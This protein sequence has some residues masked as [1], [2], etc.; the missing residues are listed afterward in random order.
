M[1]RIDRIG[2]YDVQLTITSKDGC[3]NT[4][5]KPFTVNGA[6]PKAQ[7]TVNTSIGLCSN[8][9]VSI[10]NNSTV[11]FGNITKIEV[12]WDYQNNPLQKTTDDNPVSGS[13]Y[14]F[15]YPV[16]GS[17]LTKTFEI[18]YVA[19]SGI[20]CVNES[21]QNIILSAS[22][23]VALNTLN[24]VCEEIPSFLIKQGTEFT[25]ISGSAAYSGNGISADG[26]FNPRAAT[27]GT[28]TIRYTYTATNGCAAFA[29]QPIV[30]YE[31]PAVSAGPD[32]TV[33]EGGFIIL[34]GSGSGNNINYLW[35]PNTSINNNQIPAPQVSP[36]DDITY[37]LTV[38]SGDQCVN[39][40]MVFVKVLKTPLI[41][42]AFSP[43]GDGINETWII[44]YLD[45]YPNV[46]VSV[47]NRYGQPVFHSTGYSKYWDGMYNGKPLPAGTYYYIID[48]RIAGTKKLSGWVMILR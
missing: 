35:T 21:S 41:P 27:P 46:D 17:P 8:Q 48:R 16:F 5:L 9:P 1:R 29:E 12:Y 34:D 15:Q 36:V 3:V 6:L 33:L 43:N 42:N 20:N 38:T 7:F 45:S 44:Q 14:T 23:Q 25:N 24:P 47:F 19:Y 10:T 32:K 13:Q 30:V 2:V 26:T 40:D 37:Q 11:N 22:P 28:H 18:R 31:Q 4:I 39:S